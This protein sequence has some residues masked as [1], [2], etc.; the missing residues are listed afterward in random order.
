MTFPA[1]SPDALDEE[2]TPLRQVVAQALAL[3]AFVGFA[4]L[5]LAVS[6]SDTM[7]SVGKW[8]IVLAPVFG[9]YLLIRNVGQRRNS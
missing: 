2:F 8:L 7:Q 4:G 5:A 1:D 3:L 9:I 6:P